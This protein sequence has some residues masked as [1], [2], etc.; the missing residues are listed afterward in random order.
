MGFRETV[1][2]LCTK[3]EI[4]PWKIRLDPLVIQKLNVNANTAK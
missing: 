3:F 1:C 2:P 4:I